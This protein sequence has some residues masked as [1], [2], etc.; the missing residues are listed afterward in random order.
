[1]TD[2]VQRPSACVCDW[3]SEERD[4]VTEDESPIYDEVF[5]CEMLISLAKVIEL[6]Q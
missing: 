5:L 2:S 1:M 6:Q 3:Q 4:S